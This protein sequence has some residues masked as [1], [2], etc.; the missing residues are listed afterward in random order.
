MPSSTIT[1]SHKRP[2]CHNWY[3]HVF[4][5]QSLCTIIS[6]SDLPNKARTAER[7]DPESLLRRH[8]SSMIGR[9]QREA[10]IIEYSTPRP[11]SKSLTRCR[12]VSVQL[13]CCRRTEGVGGTSFDAQALRHPRYCHRPTPE[14]RRLAHTINTP[15]TLS[16]HHGPIPRFFWSLNATGSWHCILLPSPC[17]RSLARPKIYTRWEASSSQSQFRMSSCS[18]AHVLIEEYIFRAFVITK[19]L[20]L[21]QYIFSHMCAW[22]LQKD[23]SDLFFLT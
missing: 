19:P 1:A 10:K 22:V 7:E 5:P 23:D 9:S 12:D 6:L 14:T 11:H 4:P 2:V 15:R 16:A 20:P 3:K 17:P 18:H 8:P 21:T 13:L